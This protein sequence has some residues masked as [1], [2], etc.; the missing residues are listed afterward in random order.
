M[1]KYTRKDLKVMQAW[2]LEKKIA[3]SSK[4][5]SEWYDYYD[6]QVFVSFSGGIDS[7]VLL[8][9]AR[10]VCENIPA[11]FVNT[12]VEYPEI[13]EF[14]KTVPNVEW[15]TPKLTFAEIMDK[16]GYP[17][18]SKEISNVIDGARKGQQ[19][20]FKR[21]NGEVLDKNGQP[22]IFN[23]Q[24]YKF[25]LDAP[26]KISDKCCYHIKKSP[27]YSYER[28]TKRK[29]I[30]G[31]MTSESLLRLQKWLQF[32][33]NVYESTHPTSKPLSFWK[34]Q[35]ILQYLKMNGIPYCSIYGDI[36]EEKTKKGTRLKTTGV[37]RTGCMYCMLGVQHDKIPN[38]FQQMQIT[39]PEQ[40]DF[41]I[42]T[43][44]CGA[45]MDFLGVPYKTQTEVLDIEHP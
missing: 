33:S 24:Q 7:T 13:C 16:Y 25:L 4:L 36:V 44:G 38:R 3:E 19:Y 31:T 35:D 2:P 40:Y 34:D 39:H 8:H 26:F 30:I 17:V 20:R 1:A 32:G 41:C 27:I 15:L 14:V 42:N 28:K 18:I 43:L 9:L 10:R 6:G 22:S 5:I 45:V 21:L 11:V 29:A 37:E 23:C 12:G